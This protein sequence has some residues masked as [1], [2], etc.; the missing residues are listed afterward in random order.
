MG[1]RGEEEMER[2]TEVL[3]DVIEDVMAGGEGLCFCTVGGG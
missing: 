3:V 2:N 1:K